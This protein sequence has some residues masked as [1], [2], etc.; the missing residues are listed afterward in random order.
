MT[1]PVLTVFARHR[2]KVL[3]CRDADGRLDA[4][5]RPLHGNPEA[6]ARAVLEETVS[7]GD[8]A[9]VTRV[10][11]PVSSDAIVRHPVLVDVPIRKLRPDTIEDPE[12]RHAPDMLD[13][14][15]VPGLW[16]AYRRVAPTAESVI[17]DRAHGSTT[18]SIRAMEVLRDRSAETAAEGWE[19]IASLARALATARPEMTVLPTRVDRVMTRAEASVR[20]LA[21]AAR[22][23]I[24]RA[25]RVDDRTAEHAAERCDD[26][27]VLTLSRSGTVHAALS[28]GN[29]SEVIVLQSVPGGEGVTMAELLA[30]DG[31]DV[32]LSPDAAVAHAIDEHE[33]DL[34]LVGADAIDPDGSVHNKVGTRTA[35]VVAGANAVPVVVVAATDKIAVEPVERG[36]RVEPGEVYAGE[37]DL[38]VD[39]PRFDRTPAGL[40]EAV[41]TEQGTV[42]TA[43]IAE[44]AIDHRELRAWRT[45]GA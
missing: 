45:E 42:E 33:V 7:A 18:L 6:T 10:G 37:A 12:W 15:T 34:M 3:L 17:E 13:E 43:D 26:A 8:R 16:A 1:E 4:L 39:V 27:T 19:E 14:P 21:T 30:G 29:P 38:S 5:S 36:E 2:G 9:V 23:G 22:E 20:G 31:L 25:G 44:I 28:R 11:D 41:V 32:A 35:A 40:I 24:D